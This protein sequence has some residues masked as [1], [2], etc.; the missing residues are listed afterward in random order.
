MYVTAVGAAVRLPGEAAVMPLEATSAALAITT[1]FEALKAHPLKVNRLRLWLGGALARPFMLAAV[2]GVRDRSEALSMAQALAPQHTGLGAP[3]QVWLDEWRPER[4]CLAVA[5]ERPLLDLITA[6]AN[7]H[8]I[9][10]CAI[11]PSWNAVLTQTLV[12]HTSALLAV[13]EKAALTLLKVSDQGAVRAG[14]ANPSV[15]RVDAHVQR[16]AIGWAASLEEVVQAEIRGLASG[17]EPRGYTAD[18]SKVF[19]LRWHKR[20]G[21]EAAIH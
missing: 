4:D 15:D 16:T 12:N 2:A 7:L 1:G 6:Q 19:D 14:F 18:P 13:H 21:D 5:V 17:L 9:R 8:Q 3:C 10:L 20:A 11:S